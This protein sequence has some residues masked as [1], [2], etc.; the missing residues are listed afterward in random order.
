M[1]MNR[2]GVVIMGVETNLANDIKQECEKSS[3]RNRGPKILN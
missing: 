2:E 1:T 3:C